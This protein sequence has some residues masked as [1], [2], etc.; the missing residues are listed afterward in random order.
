MLQGLLMLGFKMESAVC[1]W[2]SLPLQKRMATAIP[3]AL[4][5]QISAVEE[6]GLWTS[7]R[8]LLT[9]PPTLPTLDAS[10][11]PSMILTGCSLRGPTTTSE[12]TRPIGKLTSLIWNLKDYFSTILLFVSWITCSWFWLESTYPQNLTKHM[13]EKKLL[14]AIHKWYLILGRGVGF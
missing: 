4:E 3:P 5:M 14:G 12:T 11:T 1:A 8:T 2:M 10:R 9:T 13:T 6:L 7:T